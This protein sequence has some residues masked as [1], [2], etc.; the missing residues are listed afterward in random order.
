MKSQAYKKVRKFK[1][2]KFMRLAQGPRDG[3]RTWAKTGTWPKLPKV[4]SFL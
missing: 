2:K 4:S 1:P 3:Q